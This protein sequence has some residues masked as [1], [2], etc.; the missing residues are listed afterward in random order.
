LA[1]PT[2]Y[3]CVIYL[4]GFDTS[5]KYQRNL[6]KFF[7]NQL[8][9]QPPALDLLATPSPWDTKRGDWLVRLLPQ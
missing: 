5:D 9:F 6:R 7:R 3:K 1:R 8:G 4:F 2:S